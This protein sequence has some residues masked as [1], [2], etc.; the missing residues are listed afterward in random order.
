[1]ARIAILSQ[2]IYP[3]D[4]AGNDIKDMRRTLAGQG[5]EVGLF[6]HH[7]TLSEVPVFST[8]DLF[9]YLNGDSSVLIYHHS[10]GW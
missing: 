8:I 4:A 10:I 6:A 5:H 2:C 9:S 7:A 3:Y 1:M